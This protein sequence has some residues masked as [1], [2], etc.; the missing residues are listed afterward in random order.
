MASGKLDDAIVK[1]SEAIKVNPLHEMAYFHRAEAHRQKGELNPAIDDYTEAL[2][3]DPQH[4]AAC[5]GRGAAYL[6]AHNPGQALLDLDDAIRLAP[7]DNEALQLRAQAN[8]AAENYQ[9]AI[10]DARRAIQLDEKSADARSTLNLAL[11]K[12]AEPTEA[13]PANVV[14]PSSTSQADARLALAQSLLAQKN[15]D[16]ALK[17]FSDVLRTDSTNTAAL[18]GSGSAFFAK[19]DWDAAIADLNLYIAYHRSSPEAYSLRAQAFLN[20]GDYF[21][22]RWD[23]TEAIRLKPED[24]NAYF[25]RA[26]ACCMA[27][28]FAGALA[29][30]KEAVRLDQALPKPS[31]L[32]EHSAWDLYLKICQDQAR[33]DRAA[34]HWKDATASLAA[35]EHP[36]LNLLVPT[37]KP[38]WLAREY[39]QMGYDCLNAKNWDGAIEGFSTAQDKERAKGIDASEARRLDRPLA[40]AY[41]ERGY[42]RAKLLDL[43]GAVPDLNQAIGLY[44]QSARIRQLAGLASCKLARYYHDRSNVAYEKATWED[45]V[46]HLRR[47]I[48]LNPELE[49]EMRPTVDFAQRNLDRLATTRAVAY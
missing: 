20:K 13:K 34:R 26:D 11:A 44:P 35:I 32:F 24:A 5:R 42:D 28:D 14:S 46:A 4:A 27:K 47:A 3:L 21:R 30:L 17:V 40:R 25:C 41:A 15:Y 33:E 31:I 7:D 39:E 19:K 29:S 6:L 48:W 37:T 10:A 8:L 22:A 18:F 36:G 2:R 16:E 43:S 12:V 45:A 23:A 9:R 38:T 49:D 1:F